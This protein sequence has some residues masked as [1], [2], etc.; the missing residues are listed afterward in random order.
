MGVPQ[1]FS[2]ISLQQKKFHIAGIKLFILAVANGMILGLTQVIPTLSILAI[3]ALVPFFVILI[4]GIKVKRRLGLTGFALLSCFFMGFTVVDSFWM[5]KFGIDKIIGIA[6]INALLYATFL[7]PA[8]LSS[9]YLE[10]KKL[11]TIGLAILGWSSLEVLH[12][13]W[14]LAFPLHSLGTSLA[15][16]PALFLWFRATGAIG[17]TIWILLFAVL[18]ADVFMSWKTTRTWYPEYHLPVGMVLLGLL[19][20]SIF[21]DK[22]IIPEASSSSVAI[23]HPDLEVRTERQSMT[24]V[25]TIQYYID[26]MDQFIKEVDSVDYILAPENVILDGGFIEDIQSGNHNQAI[27]LLKGY[28]SGA[29]TVLYIGAFIYKDVTNNPRR[30]G[31]NLA[32]DGEHY[33]R[34]Y[35]V[36]LEISKEAVRI[37]HVKDRLVPFE[38]FIPFP[39]LLSSLTSTVGGFKFYLS[40]DHYLKNDRLE[41]TSATGHLICYESAFSFEVAKRVAEKDFNI[42]TVQ[43]N[44]GWYDGYTGPRKFALHATARAIETGRCVIRSSNRGISSAV[45]SVGQSICIEKDKNP[46]VLFVKINPNTKDTWFVRVGYRIVPFSIN[47]LFVGSIIVMLMFLFKRKVER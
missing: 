22:L 27:S 20:F 15:E 12:Q 41:R 8:L 45:N 2:I 28:L 43:L 23:V 21:Q 5:H 4:Q 39:S 35:N 14:L 7:L 38:E 37:A 6:I 13:T 3:I 42:L 25:Q 30:A 29:N 40:K 10:H 17:G 11:L 46:S 26:L 18:L 47:L 32:Q 44:E 34:A 19:I 24:S 31:D 1:N 9:I 36:T 33:F 16:Y